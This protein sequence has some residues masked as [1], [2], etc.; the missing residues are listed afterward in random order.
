MKKEQKIKAV[1]ENDIEDLLKHSNQ[2]E[3]FINGELKCENCG[4]IMTVEN[5]GIMIPHKIIKSMIF[6]FYCD[7]FVCIQKYH[8][9]NGR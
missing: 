5:I 7:D 3:K 4:K 6:S 2:Y 1:L 8:N 9:K